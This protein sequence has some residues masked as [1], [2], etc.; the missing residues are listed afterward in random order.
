MCPASPSHILKSQGSN[1]CFLEIWLKKGHSKYSNHNFTFLCTSNSRGRGGIKWV[2]NEE[3]FL[4][5]KCLCNS[6]RNKL[7]L[8][9]YPVGPHNALWISRLG[10]CFGRTFLGVGCAMHFG[11]CCNCQRVVDCSFKLSQYLFTLTLI[12]PL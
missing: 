7:N 9:N 3:R 10:G 2:L 8:F 5:S 6:R 12:V 1:K 4:Q 11:N